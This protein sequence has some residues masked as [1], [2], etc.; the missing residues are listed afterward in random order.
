M[1]LFFFVDPSCLQPT[2]LNKQNVRVLTHLLMTSRKKKKKK[3]II[4]LFKARSMKHE[5]NATIKAIS[6]C[7]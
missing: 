6:A 5:N 7:Y 4:P 3:Q 2:S 1:A